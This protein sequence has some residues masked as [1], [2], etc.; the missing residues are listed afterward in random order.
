MVSLMGDGPQA[1]AQVQIVH[2]E[3][4]E[5]KREAEACPTTASLIEV[6]PEGSQVADVNRALLLQTALTHV[7]L[8]A[9]TGRL[10]DRMVNVFV[11]E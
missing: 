5:Q 9:L 3:Q 4:D 11:T 2:S 6:L 7:H 1:L 8:A 10:R